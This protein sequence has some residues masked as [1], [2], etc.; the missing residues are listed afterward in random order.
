MKEEWRAVVGHEGAYEVS[1]LGN[2]RS[3]TRLVT[4][5]SRWGSR[6]QYLRKGQALA[7]VRVPNGY[8]HVALSGTQ[9][10]VHTLVLEA[11][12]ARRPAGMQCAHNDGDRSNNALSNLRWATPK[13]NNA[14]K[15]QHGTAG[16][17]WGS[18]THCRRGH[19]FAQRRRAN[20]RR[21][22]LVC[23]RAKRREMMADPDCR[24]RNERNR[25]WERKHMADPVN[26][27]RRNDQQRER[28]RSISTQ[29][30]SHG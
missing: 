5:M 29:G 25:D 9:V 2:V 8:L 1:N 13:E 16:G 28:R 7:P 24:R 30:A 14:D 6:V 17:H 21:V 23:V 26:R 3:L 18:K 12:A 15:R 4:Q 20:G 10:A 19:E 27:A 11:F 22:C